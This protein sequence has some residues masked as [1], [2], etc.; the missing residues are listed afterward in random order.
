MEWHCTRIFAPGNTAP[1]PVV[2]W[3]GVKIGCPWYS[4][5]PTPY[6]PLDMELRL[7]CP[8]SWGGRHHST[9][10]LLPHILLGA[11]LP[12]FQGWAAHIIM[13]GV[14]CRGGFWCPLLQLVYGELISQLQQLLPED[15]ECWDRKELHPPSYSSVLSTLPRELQELTVPLQDFGLIQ[16]GKKEWQESH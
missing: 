11:E 13:G 8:K 7:P 1:P 6:L 2:Y 3:R 9:R 14:C 4:V 12:G 15:E 16:K 10:P 5:F